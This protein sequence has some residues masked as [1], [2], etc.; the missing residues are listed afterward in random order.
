[1]ENTE[2]LIALFSLIGT[3]IGTYGGIKKSNELTNHRLERLEKKVDKHN[4]VIE[5]TYRLEEKVR[6]L[7]EVIK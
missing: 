3:A 5:R 1:M 2:I 7:E 6:H 4:N